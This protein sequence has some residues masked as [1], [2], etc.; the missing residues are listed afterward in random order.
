MHGL[1]LSSDVDL[2]LPDVQ[3]AAPDVT[4]TLGEERTVPEA[5]PAGDVF[6]QLAEQPERRLYTFTRRTDGIT[7]RFHRLCDFEIDADLS[8]VVCHRAPGTDG[9]FVS[10]LATGMLAT[11]LLMLRGHPVLHGSAVERGGRAIAFVGASGMGKSTLATLL[12]AAGS[13]LL[14][15]DVLRIDVRTDPPLCRSGAAENR[16][17]TQD[18]ARIDGRRTADGRSAVRAPRLAADGIPLAAVAV[19][20]PRR[21]G[22]GTEAEWLS[23]GDALVE[24]LRF[25]RIV[26]WTDPTS[27]AR[28]FEFL[29]DLV[30]RVPVA[31]LRVPWGPPFA[32]EL[33]DEVW[34]VLVDT[35]RSARSGG[36]GG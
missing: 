20:Y 7:L 25:P 3:T 5:A 21:D 11:V 12:C 2:H 24:L 10:V 26:G 14:T 9:D 19:P 29:A 22:G 36:A 1:H 4:L 31:R 16:L 28:H 8:R 27:T 30:P 23:P 33:A 34:D 35:P 32:P 18:V 13:G 6:A 17:R 15:D